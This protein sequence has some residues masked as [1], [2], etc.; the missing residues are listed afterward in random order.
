MIAGRREHLPDERITFVKERF[1]AGRYLL[2]IAEQV[3]GC[4]ARH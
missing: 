1:L 3:R 2:Y 4:D